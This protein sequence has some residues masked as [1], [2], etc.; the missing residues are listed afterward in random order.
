MKRLLTVKDVMA[1][2]S[3]SRSWVYDAAARGVLPCSR[4]GGML[5]FD[6]EEL[7]RWLARQKPHG[8]GEVIPLVRG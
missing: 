8:I 5:R 7:D 4:L 6:P 2:W 3:V 1:N